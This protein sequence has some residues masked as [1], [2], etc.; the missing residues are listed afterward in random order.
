MIL[1]IPLTPFNVINF[2]VLLMT[3][4]FGLLRY[5]RPTD[6]NLPILY[7]IG[8]IAHMRLFAGGYDYRWVLAGTA[9]TAFI[10]FEFMNKALTRLL[11]LMEAIPLGYVV[12]RTTGLILLW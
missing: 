6:S 2:G 5:S 7:W 8:I 1:G 11:L 9:V 10:R 3:V 4:G 12:W